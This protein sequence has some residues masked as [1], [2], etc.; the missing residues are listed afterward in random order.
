[1]DGWR[2]AGASAGGRDQPWGSFVS[3]RERGSGTG[4]LAAFVSIF[5]GGREACRA[6]AALRDGW[7]GGGRDRMIRL[8]RLRAR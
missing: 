7:I 2:R 1:L 3:R 8:I 4:G 5:R 6:F